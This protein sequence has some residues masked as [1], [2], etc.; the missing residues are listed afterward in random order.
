MGGL[1]PMALWFLWWLQRKGQPWRAAVRSL[2]V[3]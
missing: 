3:R 1:R 2:L